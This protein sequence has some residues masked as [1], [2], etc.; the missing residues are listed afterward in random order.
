MYPD[1]LNILAVV[2]LV[3]AGFSFLWILIDIFSGHHQHMWIMDVVWPITGLYAGPLAVWVYYKVGRLST[4]HAMMAAKE[5]GEEPPGKQKPFWQMVGIGALHCGSGCTL[6]DI[7]GEW[8]LFLFPFTLFGHRIFGSWLVDFFVAL[9]F[10]LIFQYF[11]I[12]PMR[13]LS[14]GEGIKAAVKADT[15]SLTS[16]QVGMYGWMAIA[17]FAIFGHEIAKTSPVF[18]FMM[19]IAMIAGFFTAYP[20]NWL[21]LRSGIK[22]KM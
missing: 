11:A 18:W 12:V 21:L 9:L 17:T 8:A 5:R 20:V 7:V 15:L 10:G 6:A 19:Q 14:V 1:W 2:S 16:W 13:N 4:H 22:E 3:V